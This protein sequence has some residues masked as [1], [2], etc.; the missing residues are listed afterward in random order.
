[1]YPFINGSG[2]D[3]YAEAEDE[4]RKVNMTCFAGQLTSVYQKK[5]TGDILVSKGLWGK[6]GNT[7]YVINYNSRTTPSSNDMRKTFF[8]SLVNDVAFSSQKIFETIDGEDVVISDTPVMRIYKLERVG[9]LS[10]L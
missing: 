10:W 1:M 6:K 4:F 3:F 8:P 2:C 9:K 5:T 7:I